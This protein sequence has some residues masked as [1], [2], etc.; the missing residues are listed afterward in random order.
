MVATHELTI[1]AK[2]P[3]GPDDT[4]L[5]T[6]RTNRM[7]P[8]EVVLEAVRVLTISPVYQES[9]TATLADVLQ[10][11]VELRGT[12]TGVKTTTKAGTA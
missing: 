11:E 8:C 2:C 3:H 5:A 9:L 1:A 4:Y 7:I 10:C 6:F 12:H